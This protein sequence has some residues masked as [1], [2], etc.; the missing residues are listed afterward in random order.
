MRA[1][2]LSAVVASLIGHTLFGCCAHHIVTC[3]EPPNV[4]VDGDCGHHGDCDVFGNHQHKC[5]CKG[6]S[7]CRG[8]CTYLPGPKVNLGHLKSLVQ[9]DFAAVVPAVCDSYVASLIDIEQSRFLNAE[10]PLRLHLFE[11]ILLI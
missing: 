8:L 3:D 11:Q 4:L 10:P 9:L 5:P 1:A 6:H 2:F 7:Q